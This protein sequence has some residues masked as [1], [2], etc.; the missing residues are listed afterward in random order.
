MDQLKNC[1]S[2]E[3][4]Y[5]ETKEAVRDY[6][7]QLVNSRLEELGIVLVNPYEISKIHHVKLSH[8][9]NGQ[10][11]VE[12]DQVNIGP[13]D[14][15]DVETTAHE[16]IHA[17]SSSWRREISEP[18][19]KVMGFDSFVL[20][21]GTTQLI[22]KDLIANKEI[23]TGTIS[24]SK[25]TEVVLEMRKKTA[26]KIRKSRKEKIDKF[27]VKMTLAMH[28][29]DERRL[30]NRETPEESY[31]DEVKAVQLILKKLA[32]QYAN[33]HSVSYE[34]AY[35]VV[36]KDWQR[37]YFQSRGFE[38]DQKIVSAFGEDT[39]NRI[40]KTGTATE[41]EEKQELLKNLEK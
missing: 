31:E 27:Y 38:V 24:D 14:W 30:K 9:G 18:E 1:E 19:N 22:A 13:N 8:H 40:K 7:F 21:E 32:E 29:T 15:F 5:L 20:N 36:W 26:E 25:I 16:I 41:E 2:T 34:D 3:R 17:N 23:E 37:D 10:Y 28:K 35:E 4:V 11:D 12:S 33:S 6:A 39:L